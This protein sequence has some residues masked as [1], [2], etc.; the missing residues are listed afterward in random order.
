M[1]V[2]SYEN[3]GSP[4]VLQL[5]D[6]DKPVPKKDEVL[7]KIRATTVT[8]A[9]CR[10]RSRNFPKGFGLITRFVFGFRKPK[11]KIL[12]SELSGVVVSIGSHV[13][14]FKVGDE[15]FGMS[16]MNMGCY[17]Q[18]K[19]IP[20]TG[21]IAIKPANLSFGDAAALSF[22]GTTAID[23]I[24]RAKLLSG[25]RVLVN[26][27]S[28]C[29]GSAFVQL[30]RHFGAEVTGVCSSAN[31][32][33]VHAL[34]ASHVIDYEKEGFTENG[35]L[36]DVIVDTVGTVSPARGYLALKPEGR[37]LMVAAGLPELIQAF[38][39][40]IGHNFNVVAGPATER[41]EDLRTLAELVEVSKFKPVIDRAYSFLEMKDAHYYV[42]LGHKKGNV[43][44]YIENSNE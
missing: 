24:R 41:Q 29:V 12:G 44:I 9:D 17:A 21:C 28:G 1:K 11:R 15:V 20:E 18:Y 34:G 10:L 43:V 7:I 22:G 35:C 39:L 36:Y 26:G 5:K 38:S 37:L 13:T 8:S 25:E 32:E 6:V 23:F 2:F 14:K 42:D 40:S 19:C 3:F 33:L 16:G 30:A 4:D 27:A 31:I